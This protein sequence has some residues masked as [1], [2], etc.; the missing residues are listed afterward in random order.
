MLQPL[1]LLLASHASHA[2]DFAARSG[3]D[4]VVEETDAVAAALSAADQERFG[5]GMLRL[6]AAVECL[7][8]VPTEE[9]MARYRLFRGVQRFGAGDTDAAAGEFLAARALAPDIRIPVYPDD[10]AI[11]GVMRRHDPVRADRERLPAPKSGTVFVDGYATRDRYLHA[12]AL[13]QLVD[14]GEVVTFDLDV[15]ELPAYPQRHP[16][17]NAL[18]AS[19]AGLG[20]LGVGLLAASSGPRSRFASG[21]VTSLEELGQLRSQTNTLSATGLASL[22]A[23]LTEGVGAFLWRDR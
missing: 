18:L 23:S 1:F 22:T 20:A 12:P 8:E 4:A 16:R 10:H 11:N 14:D 5:D 7:G 15:G 9:A 19:S 21:E 17:R 13:V 6:T 3:T 2:A